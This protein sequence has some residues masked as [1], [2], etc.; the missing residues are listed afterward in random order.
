MSDPLR[1]ALQG[2]WSAAAP[3]WARHADYVD[4]RQSAVTQVMLDMAGLRPGDRVLELACGPG[5]VGISAATAVGPG[6]EVLMSDVAPEMTA[7]AVERAKAHH[8]T[9]VTT[10]VIDMEDIDRPDA[11]FDVV[12]CREGLMLVPDPGA[13]VRE[14][15]RVLVPG[16]RAVFAVWGPRDRNPWLGALLDAITAKLG[17]AVP[18]PGVP[19][20]F[21]LSGYGQLEELLSAAGFV[22]V[23]VREVAAPMTASSFDEWWSVVLSLAGPVGPML[24]TQPAD[25]SAAI[26]AD[27]EAALEEFRTQIGLELPGLSFVGAGRH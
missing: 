2:S 24:A 23:S 19:G 12:L 18:P 16:G 4:D 10:A 3:A 22:D 8:L 25:V 26:R 9:N 15:H 11:A 7:I 6:G 14:S 20:P 5:G 27:A 17:I 1:Q 13:A 21:S